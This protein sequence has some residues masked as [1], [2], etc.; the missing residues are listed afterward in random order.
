MASA[1]GDCTGCAEAPTG[2]SGLR[3]AR[4]VLVAAWVFLLPLAVSVLALGLLQARLGPAGALATGAAA[5]AVLVAPAA[6]VRGVG[7]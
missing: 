2:G 7:R 3:G 1:C 4:L 6:W 5:A